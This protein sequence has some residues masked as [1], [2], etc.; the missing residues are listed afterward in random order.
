MLACALAAPSVG[1]IVDWARKKRV[2]KAVFCLVL[3]GSLAWNIWFIGQQFLKIGFY[4][5]VLG[6]EQER[7]FLI[8][9]VPGYPALEFINQN[10]LPRSHVLCV[11]TGAYGYYLDRRY[12]SD[13][14]IEDITLKEFI[15]AS[16]KGEELSKRLTKAGFTHLFLNQYW[17]KHEPKQTSYLHYF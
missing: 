9:K 7:D 2:V 17:N 5:P 1:L 16:V 3:I 14:F 11:W 13:T 10:L 8:R 4:K 12:Y 15:H 6:M